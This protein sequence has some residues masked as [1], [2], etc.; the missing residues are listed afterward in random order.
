MLQN[1]L[2]MLLDFQNIIDGPTSLGLSKD[3]K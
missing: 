3:V 2:L 1:V